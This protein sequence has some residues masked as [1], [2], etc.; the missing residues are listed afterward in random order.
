MDFEVS[1]DLES[2]EQFWDGTR[3][4]YMKLELEPC[5][6]IFFRLAVCHCFP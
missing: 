5:A 4:L 6:A 3:S 1:Y 2:A